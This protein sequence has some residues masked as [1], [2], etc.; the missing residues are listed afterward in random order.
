MKSK[1]VERFHKKK[2]LR[3]VGGERE[4]GRMVYSRNSR[5]TTITPTKTFTKPGASVR[6]HQAISIKLV[7]A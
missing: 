2:R 4:G 5:A 3:K 6:F 7:P 1:R